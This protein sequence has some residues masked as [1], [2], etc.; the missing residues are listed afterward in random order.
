MIH[1]HPKYEQLLK[2]GNIKSA[3]V[4]RVISSEFY[5]VDALRDT[6]I[7]MK[8]QHLDEL[9]ALKEKISNL[10]DQNYI[11]HQQNVKDLECS[12]LKP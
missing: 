10:I 9:I 8:S 4:E 11:L 6:I 2:L 7:N 12:S 5:E 1:P 3:Y